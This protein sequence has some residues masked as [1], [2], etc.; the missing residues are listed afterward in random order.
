M[1]PSVSFAI[2]AGM[3]AGCGASSMTGPSS[4]PAAVITPAPMSVRSVSPAAGST[5]GSTP[6]RITGSGFQIGAIITIDGTTVPAVVADGGEVIRVRTPPHDGGT[7][8]LIVTNPD[9]GEGR[10]TGAYAY[11]AAATFEFEGEWAG[12]AGL[13][14]ES[15]LRFTVRAGA[16]VSVSCGTSGP[17]AFAPAPVVNEGEFSIVT[18]SGSGFSARIVSA[19]DAVGTINLGPC[20]STNWTA[21]RVT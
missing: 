12:T 21:K 4:L 10:L 13:E 20:S 15:D 18:A 3:A 6:L 19:S 7:V 17:V 5:G 11:V 8:E 2:I 14:L 1:K 16:L 9:G